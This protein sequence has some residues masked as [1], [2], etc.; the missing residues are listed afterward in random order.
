[1]YIIKLGGSVITNKSDYKTFNKKIAGDLIKEIVKSKQQV[2][3]VHGAGSYGHI[4]A[5]QAGIGKNAVYD[6]NAVSQV[7]LDV[8]Q[9]NYEILNTSKKAKLNAISIPPRAIVIMEKGNILSFDIEIIKTLVEKQITPVLF[10]DVALDTHWNFSIISGD[11]I[12]LHLAKNLK[13]E[14]V[15]FVSDIDGVFS[16]NKKLIPDLNEVNPKEIVAWKKDSDATGGI[17]KKIEVMQNLSEI[18][19]HGSLINGKVK[20][21]LL[22]AL[23]NK[24][25]ISTNF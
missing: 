14:K 7:S 18:G 24:D 13:P 4:I 2:I 1:M 25:V 17:L 19:I 20:N 16:K 10:G 9:L 15:I 21:R 23:S 6:Y 11:D 8:L 12:I 3:L 5:K 22:N